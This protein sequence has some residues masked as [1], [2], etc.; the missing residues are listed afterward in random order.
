MLLGRGR[1]RICLRHVFSRSGEDVAREEKKEG[2][3][4]GDYMAGV[5]SRQAMVRGGLSPKTTS[6][7]AFIQG[8]REIYFL[9]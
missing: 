4:G 7:T 9:D 8:S 5:S 2:D 1:T 3:G 6:H